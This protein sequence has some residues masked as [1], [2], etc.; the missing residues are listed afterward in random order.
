MT[1][2]TLCVFIYCFFYYSFLISQSYEQKLFDEDEYAEVIKH[3]ETKEYYSI[4]TSKEGVLLAK[5]YSKLK[6]DFESLL[7]LNKRIPELIELKDYENLSEAYILK[8]ENLFN[9]SKTKEGELFCDKIIPEMEAK[10]IPSLE[11]V[12]VRCGIFYDQVKRHDK[13]YNIYQKIKKKELKESIEYI[14]NYGLIL[15]NTDRY[16]KALKFFKKGIELGYNTDRTRYIGVALTNISKIFM[17]R[18]NWAQAKVY[19]DSAKQALGKS[20]ELNYQK[21]WYNTYYKFFSFQKKIKE[22][23]LMLEDIEAFNNRVYSNVIQKRAKELSIINNRKSVLTKRVSVINKEIETRKEKRLITYIILVVLITIMISWVLYLR[24]KNIKL[25]YEQVL[26]EQEL[27]SSQMTPHFIFNALSILQGM[28]LN[29]EQSKAS[30][31]VSKFTNILEFITK[32]TVKTFI[33]L[34]EEVLILKD[35][36]DLQNLSAKKEIQFIVHKKFK[37]NVLIPSMILQP[38]I[39]NSIIHGFKE[40]VENPMITISFE[41]EGKILCCKIIDNGIGVSS[42]E[43]KKV[44]N[45]TSLA[46]KI[47]EDRFSILSKKMNDEFLVTIE[48]LKFQGKKGTLVRLQLPYKLEKKEKN[49]IN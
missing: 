42:G 27:L 22:S 17:L 7:V 45:K 41:L 25:K 5:T 24:Y 30:S 19:L 31:Y 12:C 39:E 40:K 13:A 29:N 15:A 32:D 34:K 43:N 44:E 21:E 48:D 6:R 3:L 38:F 49:E 14:T 26:N 9:L 16:D 11:E 1:F 37:Q 18:K 10:K 23:R 28:V 4:L 20:R 46:T 36:V 8:S 2:K 33:S 35:Y 47:V